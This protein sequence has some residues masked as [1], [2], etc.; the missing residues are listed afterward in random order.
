ME[1]RAGLLGALGAGEGTVAV[2]VEDPTGKFRIPGIFKRR[3]A[4]Q[5]HFLD[6]LLITLALAL[7]PHKPL[8]VSPGSKLPAATPVTAIVQSSTLFS[9]AQQLSTSPDAKWISLG[10]PGEK[11]AV[12]EDLLASGKALFA[13]APAVEEALPSEVALTIVSEGIPLAISHLVSH[14]PSA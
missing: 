5:D 6:A 11:S 9:A 7:T 2:L 13:E 4:D 8:V 12:A 1:L 14:S 10:A 3:A